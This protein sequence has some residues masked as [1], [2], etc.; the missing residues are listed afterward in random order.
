MA[1]SSAA[2]RAADA[3]AVFESVRAEHEAALAR[4]R[5][6][7][8]RATELRGASSA[9]AEALETA[10]KAEAAYRERRVALHR[11][12]LE[13]RHH[14]ELD[15]AFTQLRGELNARV[16]PE[17]SELASGFL[18]EITE[19]RYTALDIDESYDIVVLDEGEEKPVI[20]GGEEDIANL[21]LRLAVS[22]MIAERAGYPLSILILDEVFGSLDLERRD[23][24]V[25][26]LHRLEDRFDQVILITHI[27]TIREGLDHVLRVSY[28]EKTGAS[29]VTV[30]EQ[31]ALV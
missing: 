8:L 3:G 30:E 23:S 10:R 26:L 27:E 7:E 15:D 18:A 31:E 1:R 25:Q 16:R 17:L 4:L 5:A 29:V 22:Q 6:A 28:D 21:V 12:E 20:S 24:V 9:A 2:R 11:L 19:G 14:T 13:L